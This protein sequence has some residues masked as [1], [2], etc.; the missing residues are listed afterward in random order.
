MPNPALGEDGSQPNPSQIR[1]PGER[2]PQGRLKIAQ[3]DSAFRAESYREVK[4]QIRISQ[5]RRDG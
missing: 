5:S 4:D 2:V 1:I 3:C